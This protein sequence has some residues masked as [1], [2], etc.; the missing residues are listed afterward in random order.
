MHSNTGISW[1]HFPGSQSSLVEL[2]R[3][4]QGGQQQRSGAE[5]CHPGCKHQPRECLCQRSRGQGLQ[6]TLAL[7]KMYSSKQ[8]CKEV[9]WHLRPKPISNTHQHRKKKTKTTRFVK[10]NQLKFKVF[11]CIMV[12]IS[13]TKITDKMA[14]FGKSAKVLKESFLFWAQPI[15]HHVFLNSSH[16]H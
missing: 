6:T 2:E 10:K 3:Q 4:Q 11:P 12:W 5:A 7:R 8:S 9:P 16:L 13:L 15:G 14:H 1:L